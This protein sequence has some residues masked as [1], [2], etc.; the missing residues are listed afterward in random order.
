MSPV[1]D[2][3]EKLTESMLSKDC[4]LEK[5][6]DLVSSFKVSDIN[7]QSVENAINVL[8]MHEEEIR[9]LR[10]KLSLKLGNH[11]VEKV[12]SNLRK[13]EKTE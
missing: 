9:T 5:V 8:E 13:R 10:Q 6:H 3:L 2:K 12:L 1:M 11:R 4:P 7:E